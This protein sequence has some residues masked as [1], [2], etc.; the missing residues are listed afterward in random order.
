MA[1][2]ALAVEA[3]PLLLPN[4]E[5]DVGKAEPN[6]D[7]VGVAAAPKPDE[8]AA[9]GVA[10]EPNAAAVYEPNR[11]PPNVEAAEGVDWAAAA[12][13]LVE[14]NAPKPA[15]GLAELP[16]ADAPNALAV[17]PPKADTG[18]APPK[19]LVVGAEPNAAGLLV[20]PKV[21]LPNDPNEVGEEAAKAPNTGPLVDEAAEPK[22][23]AMTRAADD[24]S[25][26]EVADDGV[27]ADGATSPI[28][29]SAAGG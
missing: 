23:G 24:E 28:S 4:T 14:P 26:A 22:A 1:G 15:E 16:N 8:L 19:K 6:T 2:A 3:P 13:P 20:P 27:A 5:V 7:A 9:V 17:F 29:A 12:A 18:V 11:A 25:T 21:V 10:G